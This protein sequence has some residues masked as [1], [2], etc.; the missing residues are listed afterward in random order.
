MD[1]NPAAAQYADKAADVSPVEAH[2][3]A[4]TF[5][6]ISFTIDTRTVIPK[7][8]NEPVCEVPHCLILSSPT[9][10][11][12]ARPSERISGEFPS[13]NET[14]LSSFRF[15]RTISFLDQT[16]LSRPRRLSKICFHSEAGR[17]W[18]DS[19]S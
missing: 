5:E 17:R 3:T 18:R 16:P 6:R 19:T 7:S 8:L 2:A 11:S 4:R 12:F 14:M 9:P 13:P 10:Y 1:G 15:G